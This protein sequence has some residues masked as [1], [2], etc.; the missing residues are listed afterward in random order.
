MK[1][2]KQVQIKMNL[3]RKDQTKDTEYNTLL[4]KKR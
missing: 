3:K 2:I 4:D 1:Q